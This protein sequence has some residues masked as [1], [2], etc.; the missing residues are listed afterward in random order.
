MNGKLTKV[1]QIAKLGRD[2]AIEFVTIQVKCDCKYNN[3]R[4]KTNKSEQEQ[5]KSKSN[6]GEVSNE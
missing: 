2:G 1:V 5:D 3:G 4:V 6:I